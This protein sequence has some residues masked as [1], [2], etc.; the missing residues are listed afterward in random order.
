[1][2]SA[3]SPTNVVLFQFMHVMCTLHPAEISGTYP[4]LMKLCFVPLARM[5]DLVCELRGSY[6]RQLSRLTHVIHPLAIDTKSP[7]ICNC[8]M[9]AYFKFGITKP[10][11]DGVVI[12]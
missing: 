4:D 5:R 9:H 10:A 6:H 1:M 8:I 3:G 2:Y 12:G 7:P 11:Y